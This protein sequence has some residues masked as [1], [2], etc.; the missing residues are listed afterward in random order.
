VAGAIWVYAEQTGGKVDQT[1]LEILT[2]ARSLGDEIAAVALGKGASDAAK[3]LGEHG[4]KTV[5]MGDDEVYDDFIAQ[6]AT[7]ALHQLVQEHSPELIL[8]ALNYD[9]RDI[10][11]RLSARLGATL[12]SNVVDIESTS[13]AKTAVFGGAQI[14]DVDLEGSPRLVIVRPKSFAPEPSGGEAEVVSIDV[15]IGDESKKAK[16]VERHE[17]K[18]AGPKLEE[19][20]VVISGGRGLQDPKNFELLDQLADAIGGAAVG[21]TRAVV[22]AGWVPYAYQIGQTGKTVKPGVYIAVGISG[23]TQHMVGMKGAKKIIAINKD[24]EAPI[25]QISD[26]GVVGDALKVVPKL[27]EEVKSRKG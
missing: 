1:A 6:P 21:A 25:F 15:S 26:L 8:F 14:V 10:A 23:A 13:K 24:E 5:Y 19:A 27:I 12:M 22:D 16:R 11:G 9:S 18:A 3:E 17:E 7:E 4:A 20:E 2:K